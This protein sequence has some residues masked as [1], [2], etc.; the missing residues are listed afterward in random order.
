MRCFDDPGQPIHTV[1][2]ETFALALASNPTTGYTWQIAA[3]PR[4][5][6]L[7]AQEFE[8]EGKAVGAGGREVFRFHALEIGKTE[9]DLEYR[10]PWGKEARDTKR[11]RVTIT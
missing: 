1:V 4:Y 5:L 7:V 3:D 10:R 6:E 8:V 9:I 11:F 2:G